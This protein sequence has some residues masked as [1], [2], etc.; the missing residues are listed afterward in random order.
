MRMAGGA[1]VF[2]AELGMLVAFAWWGLVV[3]ASPLSWVMGVGLPVAVMV[4][5]GVFLSPKATRPP[6][7]AA[8]VLL[9]LALL[10]GGAAAFWAVS[11][12]VLAM[13]QA[14]LAVAGTALYE[15]DQN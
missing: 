4:A 13:G 10:L 6:P 14:L 9:R 15:R 1:L 12:P 7:H 2:V 3:F 5:W 11:E 8:R